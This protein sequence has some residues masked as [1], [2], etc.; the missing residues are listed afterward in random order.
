MKLRHHKLY[1]LGFMH[2]ASCLPCERT[3]V[4]QSHISSIFILVLVHITSIFI[5]GFRFYYHFFLGLETHQLLSFLRL[6]ENVVNAR[7]LFSGKVR[8][9]TAVAVR[10]LLEFK[11]SEGNLVQKER[12]AAQGFTAFL[13][14]SKG[15][16][17]IILYNEWMD[18]WILFTS[19]KRLY[20]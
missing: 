6:K 1:C 18:E 5:F 9:V 7:P 10:N 11:Y 14:A 12:L 3:S 20:N 4:P 8:P 17:Y 2:G 19:S 15:I 13:Q 16:W